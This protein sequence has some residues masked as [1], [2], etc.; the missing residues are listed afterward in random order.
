MPKSTSSSRKRID[1]QCVTLHAYPAYVTA[2][3]WD[4]MIHVCHCGRE[5]VRE[6]L[7]PPEAS[8]PKPVRRRTRS[9]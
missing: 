4:V 7:I 1:C 6:S 5:H 8:K 3:S 9:R 2:D